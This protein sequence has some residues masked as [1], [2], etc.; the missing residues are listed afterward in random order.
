[1]NDFSFQPSI[2]S[3]LPA[4]MRAIDLR[5]GEI[6]RDTLQAMQVI[7]G[8]VALPDDIDIV[9]QEIVRSELH[10]ACRTGND[11]L[12][13]TVLKRTGRITDDATRR[14]ILDDELYFA[15]KDG[16]IPLARRLIQNGASNLQAGLEGACR[17]NQFDAM[18]QFI[19]FGAS[20]TP[21]IFARACE[22]GSPVMVRWILEN[23]TEGID[24]DIGFYWACH[25]GN[26]PVVEMFLEM[27]V[28]NRTRGFI[29]A[30]MTNKA[31]V[32]KLLLPV[33]TEALNDALFFTLESGGID[34]LK[35][36]VKNGATN[37]QSAFEKAAE[38]GRIDV[39]Q[40]LE[41][42]LWRSNRR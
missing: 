23:A 12:I 18:I 36:I 20:F 2:A 27:G 32:A 40:Y 15:C 10:L 8:K 34:C 37:I 17:G 25:S 16:N 22:F 38:L 19:R 29:G 11:Q 31:R 3:L 9:I 30:C 41:K 42:R 13:D 39:V 6:P 1:M 4:A 5:D 35:L 24:D 26:V 21:L 28:K 7:I 14:A 33:S